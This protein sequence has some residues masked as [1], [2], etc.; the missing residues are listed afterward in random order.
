MRHASWPD[1]AIVANYMVMRGLRVSLKKSSDPDLREI[2]GMMNSLDLGVIHSSLQPHESRTGDMWRVKHLTLLL[3]AR[4]SESSEPI[5]KIYDLLGLLPA[6]ISV[7]YSAKSRCGHQSAIIESASAL[8]REGYIDFIHP[9]AC[10]SQE[11]R[12]MFAGVPSR[13]R[14]PFDYGLPYCNS[15]GPSHCIRSTPIS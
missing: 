4:G 11:G 6:N 12:Q 5:D 1:V 8:L 15:P 13:N 2:H 10:S 14:L 9:N 7:D 3:L